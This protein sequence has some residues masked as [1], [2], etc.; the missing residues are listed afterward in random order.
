MVNL[1]NNAIDAL[2]GIGAKGPTDN[3]VITISAKDEG[4]DVRLV[5]A[6]NGPGLAPAE[7]ETVFEPFYSTKGVGEGI[8][9]GL[10]IVYTIVNEL[11]GRVE[12][13]ESDTGGAR[14]DVILRSATGA[15]G[16]VSGALEETGA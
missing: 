13:G 16:T 7:R 15:G 6:D 9:I 11:G 1:V 10:S 8:G 12:T 14:F 3:P 2:T 4:G 5:I